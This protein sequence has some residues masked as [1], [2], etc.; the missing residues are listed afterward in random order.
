MNI[1]TQYVCVIE[2]TEPYKQTFESYDAA[3][4]WGREQDGPHNVIQTT[5]TV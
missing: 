1:T 4:T 3:D 2:D 5:T